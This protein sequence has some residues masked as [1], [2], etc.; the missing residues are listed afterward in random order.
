V[1]LVADGLILS[2]IGSGADNEEVG[3]TGNLAQI[4]NYYVLRLLR[5]CGPDCC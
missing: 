1:N 2:D 4:K 3:Q 5:L